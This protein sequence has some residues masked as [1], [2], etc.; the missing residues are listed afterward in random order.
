M[1]NAAIV[2]DKI[3]RILVDDM[4]LEVRL[5]SGGYQVP[6]ESTAVNI[7]VIEQ[8][9]GDDARVLLKMLAPVLRNVQETPDLFRWI[10]TEGTS[11]LFGN[12]CW[13]PDPDRPGYGMIS[14]DH[15]LLGDFL[16]SAELRGA[17]GA[18]AVTAN[19]LDDELQPRFGGQRFVDADS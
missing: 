16:D 7:R 5:I 8:G 12:A 4:E 18:V 3:Q 6:F 11:Y 19:D 1:G 2:K 17:L 10:A 9:E 14:F 15:T 13:N